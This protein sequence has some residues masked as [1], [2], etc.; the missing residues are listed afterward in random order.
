MNI[1][2]YVGGSILIILGLIGLIRSKSQN[3]SL[4]VTTAPQTRRKRDYVKDFMSSFT[5][6]VTNPLTP[7]GVLTA[8]AAV[9]LGGGLLSSAQILPAFLFGLFIFI[10][11]MSW[12]L[13]LSFLG[14][15]LLSKLSNNFLNIMNISASI[16]LSII[17]L[18]IIIFGTDYIAL[19]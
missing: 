3:I 15:Y 8:V 5:M 17:G 11:S 4:D 1:L 16:L 12:W 10:G 2:R 9:G 14:G 18:Y 6:T 19:Q 13:F 7:I